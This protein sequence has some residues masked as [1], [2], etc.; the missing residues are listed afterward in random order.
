MLPG[1]RRDERFLR[2]LI[3]EEGRYRR[4]SRSREETTDGGRNP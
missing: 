4:N 3:R 2:V 1:R